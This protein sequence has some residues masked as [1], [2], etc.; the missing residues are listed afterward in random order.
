MFCKS[1]HNVYYQY[2][3]TIDQEKLEDTKDVIKNRKSTDCTMTKSK[4]TKGQ[5]IIYKTLH[6]KLKIKQHE[7]H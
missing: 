6:R 2:I 7:I 5:I 4:K 3:V 1:K